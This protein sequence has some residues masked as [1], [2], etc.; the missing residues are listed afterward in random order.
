MGRKRKII[1]LVHSFHTKYCSPES[2]WK[3][4]CYY[5]LSCMYAKRSG[6]DI[7]LHTD[8]KGAEMLQYAPYDEVIISLN[9]IERPH[10]LFF[11]YPKFKVLEL[12]DK[13]QI[14][15]DG[16]VFLKKNTLN[17]VLDF[18]KYDCIVQSMEREYIKQPITSTVWENSRN[19]WSLCKFPEWAER[20]NIYMFNT[21]VMGFNNDSL[22]SE[23]IDIYHQMAEEFKKNGK[24]IPSCPEI[25]SEQQFLMFY[26]N[27]KNY[28]VKT[29][30]PNGL[31]GL[32]ANS[33][34]NEIGYQH[35]IGNEKEKKLKDC[36]I[37]INSIDKN[38]TKNLVI[39]K[40]KIF[41]N[42]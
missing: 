14:Q 22:K 20:K 41:N 11:A 8:D 33:Y 36:V 2:L 39:I 32:D 24:N 9:D 6:F 13:G 34:A 3:Y 1:T 40:N 42:K 37:T 29:V 38:M 10:E 19:A 26:T 25:I 35:V 17:K 31:Y 30:I 4:I 18:K 15:I 12:M 23:Y 28:S 21:G 27:L 5:T 7:V 16:D